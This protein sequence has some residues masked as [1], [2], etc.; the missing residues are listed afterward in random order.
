MPSQANARLTVEEYLTIERQAL[1]K[2]EYFNG[3]MFAMAGASR[4]HNL[5]VLNIGAELRAQLHQ[6]PC[7]VYTSDMRVKISRTGL[8]TYPDVVVVCE[9]PLFEDADVDTLL[10]PLVL[11]EVLSPSTADYDRG[12]KFEQYRT[13]P[14]L[15]AYILVAQAQC[16]V[17]HYTR[18]QDNTWLL[19]ETY[20][21]HDCLHL[22]SIR[23][24]LLLSE[25]YA[26]VQ[27]ER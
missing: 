11:V 2:S 10:N 18:Q 15:Q 13:L 26:K 25:V 21:M 16:H 20:D 27:L 14:S 3:E 22:P 5:I 24:D 9:E 23:C 6:R 17:V 1:C 19:A 8:Y 12:G 7:E 4:R